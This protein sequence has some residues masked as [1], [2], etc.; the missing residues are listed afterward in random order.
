MAIVP[1]GLVNGEEISARVQRLRMRYADNP[2]VK[3]I[4]YRIGFD[5]SD[6]PAVF[7]DVLLTGNKIVASELQR[8]AEDIR[9]DLL[10]LVRTDEIGL[11]SYLNFVN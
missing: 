2:L 1:I 11:H 4:D 5:W 9:I 3:G 7:I 10:R 6:D 8:L